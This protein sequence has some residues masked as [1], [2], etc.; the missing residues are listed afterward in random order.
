MAALVCAA[1]VAGMAGAGPAAGAPVAGRSAAAPGGSALARDVA[2]VR[3]TGAVGVTA[4][5]TTPAGTSVASAGESEIGTGRPVRG[6]GHYRTGS[7]TKTFVAAVVLQ[8]VGEGELALSD[9]VASWLPGVVEGHGHDGRRVTVRQ[10]L[11]HTSGLPNYTRDPKLFPAGYSAEGYSAHRYDRVP[12]ERLVAGALRYPP[13]FAPGTNWRYSNTNYLLLGMIVERVTGRPWQREVTRRI[14]A[15][16][17]LRQTRVPSRDPYLDHP[18]AHGYHTFAPLDGRGPGRRVDTTVMHPSSADA[19]GAVVSTP[20]DINTFFTALI[21]GRVLRPAELAEM[22]TVRPMPDEPGRGYGLGIET[23][24]L[25]CGGFYWHHGGNALGYASENGVTT[26]GRRAVTVAVNSYDAA[27][28][29]R[30]DRT[31][32]AVKGLVDRALCAGSH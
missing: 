20:A 2:A 32:A 6:D 16:L 24:P 31:D 7:T 11:Q 29:E 8:L 21:G 22:R 9:S 10:L 18:Y 12:V 13:D 4:T 26:D 19:A 23:T 15:P 1:V 17:G 5:L 28:T 30:Q 27:D 14:I 25:T 3:G